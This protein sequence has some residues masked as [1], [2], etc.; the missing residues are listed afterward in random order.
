MRAYSSIPVGA[1]LAVFQVVLTR[2]DNFPANAARAGCVRRSCRRLSSALWSVKKNAEI[3][4]PPIT[5]KAL[6]TPYCTAR[7]QVERSPV[8]VRLEGRYSITATIGIQVALLGQTVFF[9]DACYLGV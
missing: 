7:F 6:D 4:A 3:G 2:G 8:A 5:A 1:A 9:Y